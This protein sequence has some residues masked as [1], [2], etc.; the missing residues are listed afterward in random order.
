MVEA[1]TGDVARKDDAV[2]VVAG[3]TG[4]APER[5]ARRGPGAVPSALSTLIGRDAEIAELTTITAAARLVTLTGP[6]GGGKTRLA[7]AVSEQVGPAT[8][9]DLTQSADP[10][11]VPR[12]IAAALGIREIPGYPLLDAVLDRLR[13]RR[14]LLVVDNCEHLLTACAAVVERLLL[15]CPRLRVLTTSRQALGVAGELAWPVPPLSVPGDGPLPVAE[16]LADFGAV[17]LFVARCGAVQTGFALTEATAAPVVRICRQLEGNPLAL[18]LAAAQARVL[19]VDEIADRLEDSLAVLV[20]GTRSAPERHRTLRATL[21]WSYR[22]LPPEQQTLLAR[23]SVFAGGF[24]LDAV[25]AVREPGDTDD[26]LPAL[27]GL[28]DASLVVVSIV[29]GRSRYRLLDTV[30]HYARERL[31]QRGGAAAVRARHARFFA[32]LAEDAERHLAGPDEGAWL[33][34]L[35]IE[36]GNVD[37]ALRWA[38]SGF[39]DGALRLAAALWRFAYLRGRYSLC[40]EWLEAALAAAPGAPPALRARALAGAGVLAHLQCDYDT[41]TG[42]LAAALAHYRGLGDRAG[43]ATAVQALGSIARERGELDRAGELHEESLALWLALGDDAGIARS[44]NYLGFAAWLAGDLDRAERMCGAALDLHR[45]RSDSEGIAWSLISLGVVARY[46]GRLAEAAAALGES[47]QTSRDAGYSEGVAWSLDQLGAVARER[48]EPDTA[49]GLL[50]DSLRQHRGLGDRWRM[51]SV[52]ERLAGVTE[53]ER[54]AWLLGAAAALRAAAGTPVPPVEQPDR[55]ATVARVRAALPEERFRAAFA[56]GRVAVPGQVVDDVLAQPRTGP[57]GVSGSAR[58]QLRVW[59]LG[60]ARVQ[61]ADRLLTP[62]DFG[63]AKP[64]ELL[65]FL[66]EAP[67]STKEAIGLALWPA[68][69]PD[70]LRGAFHTTLHSLRSALGAAEWV[71]CRNRRYAL[72]DPAGIGYDVAEFERCR[73]PDID[74]GELR[75]ALAAYTGDYLADLPGAP[76]IDARRAELRTV[77]EDGLGRCG[78]V[79]GK[80]GRHAEALDTYRLAVAHDPLLEW[81]HRGLM[82]AYAHLGESG[83]AQRQYETVVRVLRDELGVD[84]APET[85][86]LHTEIRRRGK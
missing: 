21:D 28:I 20:G 82:R 83:S 51:A 48:G 61:L 7:M 38:L 43:I 74:T 42:R 68:L 37:T 58:A 15:D 33:D 5:R 47:L 36:R 41:A 72:D 31:V 1:S 73:A 53:P 85:A 71:R 65:F 45:G 78:A 70:R 69:S 14:R 75:A 52:L 29:G 17:R 2:D 50:R 57:V 44:L 54:A 76:W 4:D 56:A 35:E 24:D 10:D 46:R 59:A 6:G 12:A 34:R 81:A 16:R 64:R 62:A 18:E 67:E 23:L 60:S 63:Y 86:R 55:D 40:R 30:A 11:A 32:D 22:L 9:V 13:G 39:P 49:T 8:W 84:P 26:V 25:G 3:A 79:L 80:A 27:A 77:Y 66:L 19:A